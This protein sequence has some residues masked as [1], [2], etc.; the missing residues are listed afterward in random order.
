MLD[1]VTIASTLFYSKTLKPGSNNRA[2]KALLQEQN[3]FKQAISF[4]SIL[5]LLCSKINHTTFL[6]ENNY[7]HYN[8]TI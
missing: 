7:K 1:A 4:M 2:I 6:K 3:V 5:L 8:S